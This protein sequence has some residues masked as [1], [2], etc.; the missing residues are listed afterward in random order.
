MTLGIHFDN[1]V[2]ICAPVPG[3]LVSLGIYVE[4]VHEVLDIILVL[5]G[6]NSTLEVL[7]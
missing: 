5:D 6:Q 3:L 4:L 2:S 1:C 7:S